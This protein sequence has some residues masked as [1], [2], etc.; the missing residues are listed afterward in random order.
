M[1]TIAKLDRS[2]QNPTGRFL[3]LCGNVY[4]PTGW[5]DFVGRYDD[6]DT[7]SRHGKLWS[8]DDRFRWY[9]VVDLSDNLVIDGLSTYDTET[10]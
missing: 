3:L 5:T 10:D 1:R 9:Q 2:L 7:A 6:V 8:D 4:Y